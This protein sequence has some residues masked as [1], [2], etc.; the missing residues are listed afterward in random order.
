MM[1]ARAV[2]FALSAIVTSVFFIDFCGLVFQ[3][4]CR[5]LWAGADAQCNIHHA[6]VR[7]CPWCAIGLAGSVGIWTAIVAAQAAVVFW[8]R[9]VPLIVSTVLAF[10]T[11]PVAAGL[12][13]IATGLAT[14]YW[15]PE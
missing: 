15:K 1:R 7:H 10:L 4:G 11:F 5:S 2:V 8:V 9:N 13:A 6:G 12:L 14:G 3:C